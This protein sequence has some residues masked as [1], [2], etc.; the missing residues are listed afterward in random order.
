MVV[1]PPSYAVLTGLQLE[2]ADSAM[3]NHPHPVASA[4]WTAGGYGNIYDV[5][6]LYA[7]FDGSSASNPL[8]RALAVYGEVDA[9]QP[10]HFTMLSGSVYNWTETGGS[11]TIHFNVAPAWPAIDTNPQTAWDTFATIGMIFN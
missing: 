9:L 3:A 7:V 1:C 11:G 4:A 2:F 8:N 6:R 5:Y 10:A